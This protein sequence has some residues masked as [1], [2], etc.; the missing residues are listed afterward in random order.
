MPIRPQDR[1]WLTDR[2]RELVQTYLTP[3]RPVDRSVVQAMQMALDREC[4][5]RAAREIGFSIESARLRSTP[6]DLRAGNVYFAP[7][8]ITP[9]PEDDPLPQPIGDAAA[10]SLATAAARAGISA[11]ELAQAIRS[12][13]TAPGR[14]PREIFGSSIS[15][16]LQRDAH[17]VEP[18]MGGHVWV[19]PEPEPYRRDEPARKIRPPLTTGT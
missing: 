12:L 2:T 8:A 11:D 3:P 10:L 7:V 4:R 5:D 13:T 15:D 19:D 17:I 16:I 1:L 14:L 9:G 18:L 6:E